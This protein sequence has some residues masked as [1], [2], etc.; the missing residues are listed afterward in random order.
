[1]INKVKRNIINRAAVILLL[2]CALSPMTKAHA[3]AVADS[4]DYYFNKRKEAV[5][6]LQYPEFSFTTGKGKTFSNADLEG[7]ISYINLW[8]EACPPCIAELNALN[9]LYL[10]YRSDK[11]FVFI[12]FTFEPPERVKVL[13]KKY[14]LL[15]PVISISKEESYRLNQNFGFP[16]NIILDKKGVIQYLNCGGETNKEKVK[17][18]F[19]QTVY[20]KINSLRKT[21]T[22]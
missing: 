17:Q 7:K 14:H 15:Y 22:N 11:H 20:T 18:Y 10:K 2:F 13:K 6:G 4:F 12:S 16:V 1:M 8:F 5:I 19:Q 3:Q 9:S 21:Y